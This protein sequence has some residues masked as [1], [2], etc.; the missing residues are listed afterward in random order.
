MD[1]KTYTVRQL[2][3]EMNVSKTTVKRLMTEFD[4]EYVMKHSI[5]N[6]NR[7]IIDAELR[8]AIRNKANL[9]ET[10]PEQ[11]ETTQQNETDNTE[12]L[13]KMLQ[14]FETKLQYFEISQHSNETLLKHLEKENEYLKSQI[15]NKDKE[16]QNLKQEYISQLTVKDNQIQEL[17]KAL[18]Q[19]QQLHRAE[20]EQHQLLL[21]GN[22]G[23]FK[24][25]FSKR[26]TDSQGF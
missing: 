12:I 23:F 14:Q 4:S 6:K 3:E 18:D 21:T 20:Q 17:Q 10:E 24:R 11:N 16:L 2:A 13:E 26:K 8:K 25:L 15:E 19:Q 9:N 1:G 5:M 7:M 22:K